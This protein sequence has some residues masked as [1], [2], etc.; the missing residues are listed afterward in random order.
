ML[1]PSSLKRRPQRWMVPW[2]SALAAVLLLWL[3][4]YVYGY[5]NVQR[6]SASLF[7]L[8]KGN[9]NGGDTHP[10]AGAGSGSDPTDP[11]LAPT[12]TTMAKPT[13]TGPSASAPAATLRQGTYVGVTL[14]PSARYPKAIEAFRGVPYGQDTGG[15]NRF[16]PPKPVPEST[17]TFDAVRFGQVCP[18]DGVVREDM[19]ENCLNANIYRPAGL[20]DKDGYAKEGSEKRKAQLPVVV[21]VHGGGFNT[22]RGNERNMASFVAWAEAPIVAVS[23]NYRVGALGFLPSD[24][25][26]REGLLNLGLRDQQHLLEWVQDNI[27]SFGGDSGNVTIMGLSAGA[28]SIGHHLMFY[29]RSSSPAPFH[30]A[31]LESGAATARAVFYPTHPRHL[32]QFREF[33]TAAGAGGVPESEIFTHLRTLPVQKIVSAAKVVWDKYVDNVTWPFQ[34][35]IDGPN[36]LANSSLTNPNATPIIPTLPITSWLNGSHLRIPI[37]TGFNTNEGT[38]FIPPKADTNSDFRAFFKYLIPTMTDADLDK[39]ESLYPDPATSSASDPNNPYRGVPFGKGRQWARLDAAYA[40]YAYIC[41]VLQTAHFMSNAASAAGPVASRSTGSGSTKVYVYRYAATSAWH[42]ANHVDEAPVVAHDMT[43][44]RGKPG[45]RKVADRMHGLMARFVASRDGDPNPPP[46]SGFGAGAGAD[47]DGEAVEWPAFVSPFGHEHEHGD[48]DHTGKIMV[49]GEGNDERETGKFVKH[50]G[51][52]AK[53]ERLSE[54]E[55]EVC[56]FWWE[57]VWLS[58]GLG[59]RREDG[60]KAK[61]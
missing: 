30:K 60:G 33:L 29:G 48:D 38:I 56:R 5:G 17:R 35:V 59:R 2:L 27:E 51:V 7:P 3:Y 53:V 21:Y 49:F 11:E 8:G 50:P 32:I 40:H 57:R 37:L 31:I 44:L 14:L 43:V 34:P 22:G 25:T 19:G 6:L 15:E 47:E 52:P 45:L 41:P 28:H 20:V 42:A 4:A 58:E 1:L 26:A 54:F 55:K 39:L 18:T 24:V 61:L 36:P 16:R 12:R 13:A 10:G 46:R 23:F 9:G